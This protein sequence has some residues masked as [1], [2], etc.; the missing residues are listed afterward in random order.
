M[1]CNTSNARNVSRYQLAFAFLSALAVCVPAHA[2]QNAAAT[3][4]PMVTYAEGQK[5][6]VRG[7]VI[8][9]RRG[10]EILAREGNSAS[11][12]IVLTENTKIETP[13][14]PW[15][16]DRV[17]RDTA[18]LLPGLMFRVEGRGGPDGK[19]I[20]E[21]IKFS[22]TSLRTAQQLN[23][24][25]E[26]LETR[27]SANRDS[28]ER[29]KARMRDSLK[30]VNERI[31]NL[32]DYDVKLETTVNFETNS[33]DLSDAARRQLD[34]LVTRG[35]GLK[36]YLVEVTGYADST[37]TVAFNRD[38]SERRAES[39]VTYLNVVKGV[40]L[41]RMLN[42]T[43]RGSLKAIASNTTPDGRAMNRRANVRVLVNRTLNDGK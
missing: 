40:P 5:V 18:T 14:G 10:D 15:K 22:N 7:L 9:Q 25:Q 4:P 33:A 12:I 13:T 17:R 37:G 19:L 31:V 38:L 28:I 41:R 43:G 34:D 39:V 35:T 29:L 36:G 16:L 32:D 21:E 11:H 20:A 24:G 3:L 26:V 6:K 2:Q 27:V 23:V 30:L 8:I 1:Q 42:P